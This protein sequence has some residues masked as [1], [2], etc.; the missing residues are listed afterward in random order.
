MRE[1][2]KD[3]TS[4]KR[5]ESFVEEVLNEHLPETYDRVKFKSRCGAVFELMVDH[6]RRGGRWAA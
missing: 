6:A 3:T 4:K 5:V 1:W 2:F